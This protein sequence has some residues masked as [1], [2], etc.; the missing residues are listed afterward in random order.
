MQRQRDQNSEQGQPPRLG[1]P[2]AS[3]RQSPEVIEG[4]DYV[5]PADLVVQALGF[6]PEDLPVLH[7]Y[8]KSMERESSIRIE[9]SG[10]IVRDTDA[11]RRIAAAE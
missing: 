5:E 4:A 8:L 7:R 3:G 1:A 9:P 2:D 10:L 6:E 11:L